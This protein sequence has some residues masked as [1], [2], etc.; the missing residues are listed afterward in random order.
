MKGPSIEFADV[1]LVLGNSIILEGVSFNVRAGSIHCIVGANGGGKTSLVRSLAGQ[2]P[3]T[4]RISI[5]WQ[6]GRTIGYVP[7]SMEFD[8]SLPLT[9]LDFM[10]LTAPR[11]PA[12]LGPAQA[13]RRHIEATLARLGMGTMLRARPGSLS[14]GERQR[15]LFAQALVPE[16]SLL[17][18][19]EPM[20]ALDVS[21][22]AIMEQAIQGFA[23]G[24]GTVVWINHDLEQVAKLAD[25][26]T[27]IER[28]VVNA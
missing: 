23:A 15:L 22:R 25:A 4:G 11:R 3:H 9:V 16:P 27:R 6:E 13:R 7:Q 14:G 17:L 5:H 20:S 24:G 8:R 18:L 2:M 21:G 19:D 28:R 12:F 10:A 26:V 1:G